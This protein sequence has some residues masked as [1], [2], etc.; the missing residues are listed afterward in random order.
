[1]VFKQSRR[2]AFTFSSN[3]GTGI[4][5]IVQEILVLPALYVIRGEHTRPPTRQILGHDSDQSHDRL[6]GNQDG[7]HRAQILQTRGEETPV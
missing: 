1:M 2:F 6:I 5:Q 4:R 3:D 7:T